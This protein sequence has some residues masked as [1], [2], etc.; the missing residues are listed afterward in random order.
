V[1]EE[2]KRFI[3]VWVEEYP[4]SS[5]GGESCIILHRSAC[6]VKSSQ[7][8]RCEWS[9]C[10]PLMS[11]TA[12]RFTFL[13]PL[14]WS[15]PSPF[16]DAR[17]TPGYMHVL[18]DI[19]PRKEDRGLHSCLVV[20]DMPLLE[21]RP[22][23]FDAIATCLDIRGSVDVAATKRRVVTIPVATCLSLRFDWRRGPRPQRRESWRDFA[24]F[25]GIVA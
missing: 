16:I 11:R 24:P 14:K 12:Y 2:H 8:S 17:G 23:S 15:L 20:G 21:E 3:L 25:E 13:S 1:Q 7:V 22:L 6:R 5:G 4:T 19:F 9:V 18:R 10:S